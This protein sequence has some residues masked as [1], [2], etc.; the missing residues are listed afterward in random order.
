MGEGLLEKV[1]ERRSTREGSSKK[2]WLE[3]P[4]EKGN[5]RRSR[6]EGPQEKGRWRRSAG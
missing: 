4:Q 6:E 1:H 5:G 3:G 2:G